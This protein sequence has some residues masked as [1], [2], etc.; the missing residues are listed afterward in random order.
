[1]W[2][3]AGFRITYYTKTFVSYAE[4]NNTTIESILSFF[5]QSKPTA[6]KAIIAFN[7]TKIVDP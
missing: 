1:M 2:Y 7:K 4:Q 6:Y 5:Y 3:E